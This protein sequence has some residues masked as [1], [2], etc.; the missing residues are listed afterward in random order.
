M[1][2]IR[3]NLL[4][5]L[6]VVLATAMA[7]MAQDTPPPRAKVGVVAPAFTLTDASGKAQELASFR[8]RIV[9]LQWINPGCP[10]CRRVSE[11]GLVTKMAKDL[12]AIDSTVVHLTINSTNGA[13]AADTASYLK[14]HGIKAP[15]LMDPDGTVGRLYGARTTPHVFVI[16]GKGILRYSGAF[17]DDERVGGDDTTNYA[18]NAVRQIKAGQTVAPD[19]TRPYGCRVKYA[20]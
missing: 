19:T 3:R 20:R 8:G 7:A 2:D 5:A 4:I 15:G 14:K 16:D 12:R 11:A 17:D 6:T 13:N 9:V 1:M 18:V 10:V